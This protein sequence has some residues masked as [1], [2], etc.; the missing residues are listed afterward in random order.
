MVSATLPGTNPEEARKLRS[1]KALWAT[2]V[3]SVRME[4][5]PAG[6]TLWQSTK[7]VLLLVAKESNLME[8]LRGSSPVVSR[9]NATRSASFR[10]AT[11]PAIWSWTVTRVRCASL[12]LASSSTTP[13]SSSVSDMGS[14]LLALLA[15]RWTRDS[16]ISYTGGSA[17]FVLLFSSLL[18][19]P[20]RLFRASN[21]GL[22]LV[23]LVFTRHTSPEEYFLMFLM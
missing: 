12:G 1:N 19:S 23:G 6:S 21:Q 15:P 14:K 3:A 8:S 22:P 5:S 20:S 17:V 9:S 4:N 18:A 16:G 10:F 11:T 2:T 13:E 7:Y